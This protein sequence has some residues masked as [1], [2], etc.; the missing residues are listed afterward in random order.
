MPDMAWV[1]YKVLTILKHVWCRN[2]EL[3]VRKVF[4]KDLLVREPQPDFLKQDYLRILLVD[5]GLKVESI[6]FVAL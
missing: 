1:E 5:Q 6:P 2:L 3:V 4:T